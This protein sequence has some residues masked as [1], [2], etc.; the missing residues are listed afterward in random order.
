M[1]Y[2]SIFILLFFAYN[3]FG[4]S[5]TFT[6]WENEKI[7]DI[8]KL[9][10]HAI[11]MTYATVPQAIKD[12]YAGSPWY[13]S[14]N[15]TWKFNYVDQPSKA[16]RIFSKRPLMIKMGYHPCPWQLGAQ[17]LWYPYLHQYYISLS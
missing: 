15:G 16:P 11:A 12:D 17:W 1:R 13:Q 9:A 10:P 2:F 8:N 7:V 3:F 4:Q 6:E 14:L 5:F